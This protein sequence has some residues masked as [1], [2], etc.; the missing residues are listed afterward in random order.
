[1]QDG[2]S[3]LDFEFPRSPPMQSGSWEGGGPLPFLL[4]ELG[5]KMALISASG[6]LVLPPWFVGALYLLHSLI[7]A[8][9]DFADLFPSPPFLYVV[10]WMSRDPKLSWSQIYQTSFLVLC[11]AFLKNSLPWKSQAFLPSFFSFF[12]VTFIHLLMYGMW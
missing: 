2:V 3:W 9:M 1:M 10:F 5:I 6:L 4:R 8:K 12:T 11:F 7:F